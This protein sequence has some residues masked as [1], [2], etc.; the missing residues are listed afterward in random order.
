[1][2]RLQETVTDEQLQMAFRHL[3]RP[4]WP[5]TLEAPLAHPILSI[6]LR[7]LAI[8]VRRG[9][10]GGGPTYQAPTPTG[11][12]PVPL[13]PVQPPVKARPRLRGPT[14]DARRAA[15]NDQDN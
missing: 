14:F 11:A 10:V 1:M 5:A 8:N 3:A 7:A 2:K 4:G 13:T 6:C 15:A 9:G 12:P